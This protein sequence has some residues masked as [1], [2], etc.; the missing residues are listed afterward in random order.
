MKFLRITYFLYLSLLPTL[1]MGALGQTLGE[2]VSRWWFVALFLGVIV[3]LD[4]VA[5]LIPYPTT[6]SA[7]L[8]TT[9]AVPIQI[10]L[11]LANFNNVWLIFA[12]QFLVEA[13]GALLGIGVYAILIHPAQKTDNP[14]IKII[15][16]VG[17]LVA[18]TALLALP[19]L[20]VI[21]LFGPLFASTTW[22]WNSLFLVSALLSVIY[23]TIR[24]IQTSDRKGKDDYMG[25]ILLGIFAFIF[26][27]PFLYHFF[28]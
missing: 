17:K 10:I 21:K 9:L 3:F 15:T 25:Y 5:E 23:N 8:A 6:L 7:A 18:G 26:G 1:A 24:R 14:F 13:A 22:S 12:Y 11:A 27:G 20:G 28:R 2:S 16:T 4:V 19:A